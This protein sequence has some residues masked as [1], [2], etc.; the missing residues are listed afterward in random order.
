[1]VFNCK[2]HKCSRHSNRLRK[3]D[4]MM[5]TMQFSPCVVVSSKHFR[6]FRMAQWCISDFHKNKRT[7]T[8]MTFMFFSSESRPQLLLLLS[9]QCFN[10]LIVSFLQFF[11]SSEWAQYIMLRVFSERIKWRTKWVLMR[12]YNFLLKTEKKSCCRLFWLFDVI[13]S[14]LSQKM[15]FVCCAVTTP[16]CAYYI[17]KRIFEIVNEK[18]A[19]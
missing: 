8:R 12:G 10:H 11:L 1:M 7:S 18:S 4:L 13:T 17:I 2:A 6:C 19:L 9:I 5:W 16:V 14:K 15:P 3:L